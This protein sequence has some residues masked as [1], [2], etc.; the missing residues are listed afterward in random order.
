MGLHALV[1]PQRGCGRGMGPGE[2][3]NS[4]YFR[5]EGGAWGAGKSGWAPLRRDASHEG[6]LGFEARC[7]G[8]WGPRW[9]CGLGVGCRV[10]S[11]PTGG[12]HVSACRAF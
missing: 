2:G 12:R 9:L 10:P 1:T 5:G 6:S 3:G 7:F 11:D 8:G 4:N